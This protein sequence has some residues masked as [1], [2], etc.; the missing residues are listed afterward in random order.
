MKNPALA[1]VAKHCFGRLF[2][3]GTVNGGLIVDRE[4]FGQSSDN[5][6]A[7]TWLLMKG[8]TFGFKIDGRKTSSDL[9]P[10][11]G[12]NPEIRYDGTFLATTACNFHA[13]R[14]TFPSHDGR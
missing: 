1:F 8:G 2:A 3:V 14:K 7:A 12:H 11:K 5:A 9:M 6:A 10:G 13:L 4:E